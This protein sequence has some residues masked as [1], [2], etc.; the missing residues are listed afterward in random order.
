MNDTK[1]KSPG[2]PRSA[3]SHQAMLKAALGLLSEVGFEAMSIEAIASR[4]GVG[5]TTIY[6]R[7]SSKDELVADAIESIREEV[8]IPDT[9]NLWSD[10]DALIENAAQITLTPI[11]RQA[12]AMIIS[13]ASSNPGFAQVYWEKYLQPRRQ[14]FDIVIERAKA[15]NEISTDLDSG[16]VFDT[17]S[18]IMLYTLIFP[19]TESWKVYI[20]RALSLLLK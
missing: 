9:G 13:S 7:Y 17:M 8:L 5:K 12:V 4:A 3:A 18:G 11:G 20:R 14:A 10:I 2:R 6:R 15:K 16:L 19:P 1:K